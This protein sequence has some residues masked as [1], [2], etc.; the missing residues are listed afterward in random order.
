MAQN[1]SPAVELLIAQIEELERKANAY[2]AS[3]NVLCANDGLPPMYPD[4]GGG[5][6]RRLNG[7]DHQPQPAT[8]RPAAIGPDTFHGRPQQ[9]AV[10]E[11]LAIRRAAD[12]TR[13]P[14]KPDE[15]LAALKAGGYVVQ[16]KSDEIALVGLR[17]M[18]R[19]R[20]AIFYK[21][22]NGT[23]GLREWYP[24]ARPQAK[25][26]ADKPATT[27]KEADTPD[28]APAEPA[29]PVETEAAE[30]PNEATAAA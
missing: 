25:E 5:G 27:T 13:G 21:L 15:I 26:T 3:V 19:K 4:D 29:A 22:P 20:S 16:A 11:L 10:R 30:T 12:P 23:W 28:P 7:E 14:A 8:V 17:A 24:N 18:L 6:G 2:K 1:L 9:T